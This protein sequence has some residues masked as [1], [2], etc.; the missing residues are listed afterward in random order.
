MRAA[1]NLGLDAASALIA[2]VADEDMI[3]TPS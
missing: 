2:A 1:R 3:A